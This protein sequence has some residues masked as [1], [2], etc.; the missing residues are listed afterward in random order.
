MEVL[1]GFYGRR[2]RSRFRGVFDG[3]CALVLFIFFFDKSP[4]FKW[5][6]RGGLT[7]QIDGVEVIRRQIEEISVSSSNYSTG[8]DGLMRNYLNSVRDPQICTGL[9]EHR[10]YNSSCEYLIANPECAPGGFFN[11]IMF[12]YC[13][14]ENHSA[15]GYIVLGIWLAALFYLLG[16]TAADYFCC[17]LEKLSYLMKLPPTVAGVT[18]LPLGNGAPDV[19]ASIAA[20]V[21][22]DAGEVG[23][24]SVLGGALFVTCIVVGTISLSVAD[25][26][27][28]INKRCFI[29]D[30]CFL[31]FTLVSLLVILIIGEVGI[32]GAIAYV[33]IYVVYAIYI[34]AHEISRKHAQR[35][36]MN[37]VPPL[38][39]V[40]QVRFS[41]GSEEDESMCTSML[42]FGAEADVPRLETR[43]PHWMWAAN[44]AIF[45]NETVKAH[46]EESPNPIWGW[47][48][49][50]IVDDR[51][52]FSCSKLCALLELPL[53][54]PRR[55]T[56]PI[57]EEDRWS[58]GYGVA[59]VS[60]APM[61]LA[62]VWN[63]QD[64][65]SGEI[66]YIV[67]ALVGGILGVLALI[68]T[69]ADQPPRKCSFFWVLGGFIMSIVWFYMVANELVAVLVALGVIFGIK[70]SIL[71]LTVLAWGNSMGDLMSNVALAMTGRD[72]VQIAISGCYAGPMFNTLAGLG[73]SLLLGAW[74]KR[75]ASY[76]I[77]RDSSL[78]FTIG[79]LMFG[80]VWALI[81]LPRKDMRPTKMLGVGLMA[82]YLAFLSLRMSI[83][84]GALSV[85]G[86]R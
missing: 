37:M 42:Q 76:M 18:L 5:V 40:K 59:S 49:E 32:W 11:Y 24:N 38:L 31:L 16:N 27:V 8:N 36:E 64:N 60:L 9:S 30:V 17:S 69:R 3:V 43:L 2:R 21:G 33:S 55:L 79:F 58:K 46:V 82:I 35:R 19:F 81:E 61:L 63:T 22:T 41:D 72:G 86:S 57:I 6:F 78:Y 44:V 26:R 28:Q 54:I 53:T 10:R 29:R 1:K 83:A 68:Y 34:A 25:Q 23:L 45:S 65:E 80:L 48:D 50:E 47:N 12:F 73:I 13:D 74:S 67:G 20:F 56:I 52:S 62:F 84:I 66:A 14:C 70:P 77:P 4:H 75:P 7:N 39:P 51:P 85:D 71:G 15:I